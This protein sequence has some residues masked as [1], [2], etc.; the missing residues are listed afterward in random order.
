MCLYADN[1]NGVVK[2]E[3]VTCYKIYVR[4]CGKYVSPFMGVEYSLKPGDE[5]VAEGEMKFSVGSC[6]M[7]RWVITRG[8]IHA[9]REKL[10]II[11]V[12]G[13]DIQIKENGWW[14]RYLRAGDFD[15]VDRLMDD[16]VK[17]LNE[18]WVI[19]EMEIP[20]KEEFWIGNSRD[21]CARR[22][23]FKREDRI[24]KEYLLKTMHMWFMGC[25]YTDINTYLEWNKSKQELP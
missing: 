7:D 22:M 9:Y 2:D 16:M 10:K 6:A 3:P 11:M 23:I 18:K 17:T 15:E 1:M 13:H 25:R 8:A 19:C 21:I 20:A 14:Q 4:H 5:V 12:V 24:T